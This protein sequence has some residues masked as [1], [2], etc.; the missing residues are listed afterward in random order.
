VIIPAYTKVDILLRSLGGDH[1]A[2]I[3]AIDG[4]VT[5]CDKSNREISVYEPVV[6][7]HQTNDGRS[8]VRPRPT[9]S[10]FSTATDNWIHGW[11]MFEWC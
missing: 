9:F 5:A 8:R 3:A 10:W 11:S 4:Y 2:S 1:C 7:I 6:P